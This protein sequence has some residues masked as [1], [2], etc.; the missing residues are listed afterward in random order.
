VRIDWLVG[1]GQGLS[2]VLTVIGLVAVIHKI[3]LEYCLK[4]IHSF[5][6]FFINVFFSI[7]LETNEFIY[8]KH[9]KPPSIFFL[10]FF[11]S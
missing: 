10:P 11:F 7:S 4:E 1:L 3:S 9:R 6:L 2:I 5:F 8:S